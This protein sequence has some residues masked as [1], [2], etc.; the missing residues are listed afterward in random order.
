MARLRDSM[1]PRSSSTGCAAAV[2]TTARSFLRSIDASASASAFCSHTPVRTPMASVQCA[3]SPFRLASKAPRHPRLCLATRTSAALTRSRSSSVS[4][5]STLP[6]SSPSSAPPSLSRSAPLVRTHVCSAPYRS[7]R[8]ACTP[9]PRG[10]AGASR[11][12]SAPRSGRSRVSMQPSSPCPIRASPSFI[13]RLLASAAAACVI[14][15]CPPPLGDRST[16]FARSDACAS[17]VSLA[18]KVPG[19]LVAAAASRDCGCAA[20]ESELAAPEAATRCCGVDGADGSFFLLGTAGGERRG[21]VRTPSD[22][23]RLSS[24]TRRLCTPRTLLASL[25]RFAAGGGPF[26]GVRGCDVAVR[27]RAPGEGR[28]RAFP[29]SHS[30]QRH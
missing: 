24:S 18:R 16:D 12:S 30:K 9:A 11:S 23:A 27:G 17:A 14:R 28:T 6:P 19:G 8:F 13:F 20:P 7:V 26:L 21:G 3:T 2:S 29:I 15:V 22:D 5:S 4:V 1:C 25:S 10:E